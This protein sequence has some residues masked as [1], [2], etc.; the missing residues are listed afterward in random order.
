MPA[1]VSVHVRPPLR[2]RASSVETV[3]PPS[4]SSAAVGREEGPH[5]RYQ[6]H[7]RR[8]VSST[9]FGCGTAISDGRDSL[10]GATRTTSVKRPHG[11][12]FA[13]LCVARLFQRFSVRQRFD[14]L[15]YVG[16]VIVHRLA[17]TNRATVCDCVIDAAVGI[18]RSLHPLF[19]LET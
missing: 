10:C 6:R 5:R 18:D 3:S 19:G 8:W 14:G 4:L 13:H 12:R 15:E 1:L 17:G 11:S 2:S 7:V 9:F 16:E